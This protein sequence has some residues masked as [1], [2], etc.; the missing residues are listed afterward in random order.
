MDIIG[1][2][3]QEIYNKI[4][5]DILNN[6][7][8]II[9][10]DIGI[11]KTFLMT[12]FCKENN[13]ECINMNDLSNFT[14]KIIDEFFHSQ[15]QFGDLLSF[16]E[17]KKN[18]V[19][20]LD[21]YHNLLDEEKE[22]QTILL[23]YIKETKNLLMPIVLIMNFDIKF[24]FVK[25][26][27]LFNIYLY[28]NISVNE[29]HNY[30][31]QL[32]IKSKEN[33]YIMK[34]LK[35][36]KKDKLLTHYENNLI[37]QFIKEC[38]YDIRTINNNIDIIIY[39]YYYYQQS[40]DKKKYIKDN[41]SVLLKKNRLVNFQI[42]DIIKNFFEDIF[43]INDLF[44]TNNDFL[45]YSILEHIPNEILIYRST[46]TLLN[47][48]K[49]VCKVLEYLININD[50]YCDY[51]NIPDNEYLLYIKN[52]LALNLVKKFKVNK[53][54]NSNYEHINYHINYKP[55]NICLKNMQYNNKIKQ[56][57]DM[58]ENFN[59]NS[60]N[61]VNKSY[62]IYSLNFINNINNIKLLNENNIEN[63][64]DELLDSK[65]DSTL[66]KYN[67]IFNE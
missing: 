25:Y 19:L 26:R 33:L 12:K 9:H 37:C 44:D 23:N 62:N 30:T 55:S 58:I 47:N 27:K 65:Y 50:N 17:E 38:F 61:I 41:N 5:D 6:K 64:C 8:V 22:I 52:C 13:Y 66:L 24:S 67:N 11:G 35:F 49:Y 32:Y 59:L 28:P 51:T 34:N 4:R 42:N 39:N 2:Q 46:S 56:L 1:I 36:N 57:K 14:P 31:T 3:R 40:K 53:L 21:E 16:F 29:V 7:L 20:V 54:K 43:N 60:K 15:L 48:K 18:K 10:G 63:M 45:L